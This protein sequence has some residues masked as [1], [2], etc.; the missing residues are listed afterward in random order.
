MLNFDMKFEVRARGN[1]N[2]DLGDLFDLLFG[3]NLFCKDCT[4]VYNQT[5]L[6]DSLS[7]L[8]IPVNI[9]DTGK[10]KAQHQHQQNQNGMLQMIRR[11]TDLP[12]IKI[13][14]SQLPRK[15][16]FDPEFAIQ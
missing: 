9:T 7:L 15:K 5:V 16:R 4:N 13:L 10:L 2:L 6:L 1:W 11:V 8:N 3:R 14:T 12:L